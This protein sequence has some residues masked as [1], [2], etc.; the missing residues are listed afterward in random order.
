MRVDGIQFNLLCEQNVT[1]IWRKRAFSSI[2]LSYPTIDASIC[3]QEITDALQVF[4]ERVDFEIEN[5][6]PDVKKYSEKIEKMITE[7]RCVRIKTSLHFIQKYCR[8]K[9]ISFFFL[10]ISFLQNFLF[11]SFLLL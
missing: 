5:A 2:A 3:P 11:L 1:N 6:V 10:L 8:L 9:N 7:H 4:R